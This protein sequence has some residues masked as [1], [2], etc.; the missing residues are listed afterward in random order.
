[1]LGGNFVVFFTILS[2]SVKLLLLSHEEEGDN[3]RPSFWNKMTGE[4]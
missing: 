2:G 4:N 1:M 3:L